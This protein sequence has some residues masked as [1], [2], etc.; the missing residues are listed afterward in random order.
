[1]EK[2]QF[3]Y[4]TYIRSTPEKIWEAITKPEFAR[5]YWGGNG[6]HSDWQRGSKWEHVSEAKGKAHIVGEVLESD[7]PKRLVLSWIDPDDT[8]DRSKVTLELETLDDMVRLTVLHGEFEAETTML[9]DIS[10]GWPKV[11]SSLKSW[12][13]TGTPLQIGCKQSCAEG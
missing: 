9:Q 11:L 12:L 6:N 13:E 7:P 4:T 5:Q 3:V 8:A 2:P 10:G 1:M